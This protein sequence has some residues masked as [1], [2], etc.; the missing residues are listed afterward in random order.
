MHSELLLLVEIDEVVF[1]VGLRLL[2]VGE[3]RRDSLRRQTAEEG[4]GR[5]AWCALCVIDLD[6]ADN[7]FRH[8]TRRQLRGEAAE[9]RT[10]AEVE[11]AI[12]NEIEKLQKEEVPAQELQK[13]KNNFAASEYRRL[14]S[15]MSIL[16]QLIQS[17]GEGDWREINEAGPKYQAVTAEDIQRVAKAY[18]TKENRNVAI[19]TR[20]PGKSGG[21]ANTEDKLTPQQKSLLE[22]MAAR[23]K[24]EKDTE[25]L[26]SAILKID[27][28]IGKADEKATVC[29]AREAGRIGKDRGAHRA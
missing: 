18:F 14:T 28:E 1:A 23:L 16:M 13:V 9:G 11:Q 10:P 6:Q 20:K 27:S 21:E 26:G 5:L 24:E 29:I 17:D 19:Y 12:Y 8:S 7:R 2:E 3:Q 4:L 22:K 15:N 25:K